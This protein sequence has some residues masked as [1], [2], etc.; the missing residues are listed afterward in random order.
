MRLPPNTRDAYQTTAAH[1]MLKAFLGTC[2]VLVAMELY[3][4]GFRLI[5]L[6]Y[7]PGYS[8]AQLPHLHAP[9]PH[10]C[11]D[12]LD[13]SLATRIISTLLLTAPRQ[14]FSIHLLGV[15]FSPVLSITRSRSSSATSPLWIT[16]FQ[17]PSIGNLSKYYFG[18]RSLQQAF[19]LIYRST[20]FF[21]MQGL[22]AGSLS[23]LFHRSYPY[24]AMTRRRR[25]ARITVDRESTT[26]EHALS[27]EGPLLQPGCAGYDNTHFVLHAYWMLGSVQR[28]IEGPGKCYPQPRLVADSKSSL[29]SV[30]LSCPPAL[31]FATKNAFT[32]P[33]SSPTNTSPGE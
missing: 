22:S 26:G 24:K 13:F 31:T 5:N 1:R 2:V 11:A 3:E 32:W 6:N 8:V 28:T 15:F 19:I 23:Q 21:A 7:R 29:F 10:L 20:G 17:P 12:S 4:H 25:N 16:F 30:D 18:Q 9:P 27:Y 33:N 14:I